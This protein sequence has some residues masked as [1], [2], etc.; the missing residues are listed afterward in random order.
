MP[1][2][3]SRISAF[4]METKLGLEKGGI[5]LRFMARKDIFTSVK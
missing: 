1:F 3:I 4:C 5:V 2:V